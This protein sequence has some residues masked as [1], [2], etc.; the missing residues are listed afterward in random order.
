MSGD[1]QTYH[2]G[3]TDEAN[4]SAAAHVGHSET[5]GTLV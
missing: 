4:V 1:V 5:T 3:Q 2:D